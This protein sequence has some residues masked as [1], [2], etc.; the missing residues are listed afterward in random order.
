MKAKGGQ[1]YL[2]GGIDSGIY[3]D[4]GATPSPCP[5]LISHEQY[6]FIVEQMVMDTMNAVKSNDYFNRINSPGK[7]L[8][9]NFNKN[10]ANIKNCPKLIANATK[11]SLSVIAQFKSRNIGSNVPQ[12]LP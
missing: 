3:Y 11:D 4:L 8:A 2:T 7:K 6:T 1:N 12:N 5:H 10:N 9:T